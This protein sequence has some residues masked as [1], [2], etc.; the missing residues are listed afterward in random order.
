MQRKRERE[1]NSRWRIWILTLLFPYQRKTQSEGTRVYILTHGCLCVTCPCGQLRSEAN[2]N[3]R[4]EDKPTLR[5]ESFQQQHQYP[6]ML[7]T[8]SVCEEPR[9]RTHDDR[10][11]GGVTPGGDIDLLF[12]LG[13][14][15][16][17]TLQYR[18]KN[19]TPKTSQT[20]PTMYL[21]FIII[22]LIIMAFC[23]SG[24]RGR[25]FV[26]LSFILKNRREHNRPPF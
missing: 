22:P 9:R 19:K 26:S 24:C 8:S 10:W 11:L 18:Y 12:T 7:N 6:S 5:K 17:C 1:T 15:L 2:W 13:F 21:W 20:N 16:D 23:I 4:I 14:T 3:S 25:C